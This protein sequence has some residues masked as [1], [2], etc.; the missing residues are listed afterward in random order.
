MKGDI[1]SVKAAVSSAVDLMQTMV[2]SISS[3]SSRVEV[4]NS[5]VFDLGN[6]A[7]QGRAMIDGCKARLAS[8]ADSQASAHIHIVEN[9]I[10]QVSD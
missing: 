5:L 3:I 2:S 4:L 9:F 8:I 6:V 10:F 1:E 7:A